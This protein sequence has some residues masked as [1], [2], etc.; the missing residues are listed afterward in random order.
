MNKT[1]LPLLS[2]GLL[3]VLLASSCTKDQ[4]QANIEL[5]TELIS[6]IRSVAADGKESYYILPNET[7]LA[8]IPQDPKNPL[9]VEKVEL[10][11]LLFF[12]TGLG[13][14]AVYESG[15]GT[16]SCA[17]CHIPAAGFRPGAK[18]GIADGGIGFGINGEG[19][20]RNTEYPGDSLDAQGARPISLVNVAYVRNT[21]WNGQFGSDGVNIGTEENWGHP[22]EAAELNHLGFQGI[23][24][25]NI[26]GLKAHR[27]RVDKELLEE[28]DGY[29]DMFD[30][31]FPDMQDEDER[32]SL[33]SASLAISA[34]IRTILSNQAPFQNYLKG[35]RTAL[36]YEE[37]EGAILFFD[38]AKCTNC[39]HNTNLG[40]LEFHA[41]GVNDLHEINV[42]NT[43]ED[44]VRNLGRGGFLDDRDW[45][46]K[47][48]VPGI[49]NMSDTPFYF[50]GSSKTSLYDVVEYK[51]DRIAENSNV[52]ES[53]LS[54]EWLPINL[55]V[56]EK[57]KLVLFLE[58]SLRDPD[59]VRY[60]PST[61]PS[62][63]C[64]PNADPQ[65]KIDIGCD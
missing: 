17:S 7:D 65:S 50:H 16:Y 14:D 5:D 40:S 28:Y 22:Q 54:E 11:K 51:T 38:K 18:Q 45:D 52:P 35:D 63:N 21:F 27:Y 2:F 48:K 25:Q 23:E 61:V 36:S 10:G 55:T 59:L 33:F 1:L 43:D 31:A 15:M 49:Y 32:Y 41:L 58:K 60:Q 62:G 37:K 8:A 42:F 46:Y 44:D 4:M 29:I 53:Q 12:D 20:T 13:M 47:F 24:T 9:T 3:T 56:E 26:E 64:F 39:H 6:K 57:Q 30:A 19:R 34:Y